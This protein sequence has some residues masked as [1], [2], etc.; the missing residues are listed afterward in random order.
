MAEQTVV[1][2]DRPELRRR[3]FA[4]IREVGHEVGR[5]EWQR[6]QGF[7]ESASDWTAETFQRAIDA[8]LEEREEQ[9]GE[10]HRDLIMRRDESGLG[11]PNVNVEHRVKRHSPTGL[12][13]GY[14][15]SGP[16][17]L[18]LN[19]LLAFGCD[20]EE[21]DAL[22]QQFKSE[23]IAPLTRVSTRLTSHEIR[24]WIAHQRRRRMEAS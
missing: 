22:Y 8:L 20:E 12:E 16:A 4:L 7:P 11:P 13:W 3:Y 14:A 21:A 9:T 1:V 19:T 23:M 5:R 6:E 17:D 24:T 2:H 18:A 10:R 15:G